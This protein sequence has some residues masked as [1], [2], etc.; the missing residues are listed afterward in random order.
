MNEIIYNI[1]T[2]FL[3]FLSVIMFKYFTLNIWSKLIART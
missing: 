2:A 3:M 1:V